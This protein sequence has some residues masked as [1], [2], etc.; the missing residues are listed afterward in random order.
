MDPSNPPGA[1]PVQGSESICRLWYGFNP[2]VNSIALRHTLGEILMCFHGVECMWAHSC[3][4]LCT[5]RQSLTQEVFSNKAKKISKELA[6]RTANL[7]SALWPKLSLGPKHRSLVRLF[8]ERNEVGV[9]SVHCCILS[10]KNSIRHIIGTHL[11]NEWTYL[12]FLLYF[13]FI[14]NCSCGLST[15]FS[16]LHMLLKGISFKIKPNKHSIKF[17]SWVKPNHFPTLSMQTSIQV[18]F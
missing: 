2:F 9:C 5:G 16:L 14:L 1:E 13:V 17:L 3:P 10:A 18:K 11:L 6:F 7:W 4:L 8:W 12:L 15:S